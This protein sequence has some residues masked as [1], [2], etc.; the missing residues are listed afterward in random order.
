MAKVS[1]QI[2]HY[3]AHYVCQD[4]LFKDLMDYICLLKF[5]FTRFSGTRTLVSDGGETFLW[6]LEGSSKIEIG[7]NEYRMEADDVLLIPIDT[8]FQLTV[9]DSGILLSCKMSIENKFRA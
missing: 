4:N 1:A 5:Y 7:I 6:Q 2:N 3:F 8:S 9:S